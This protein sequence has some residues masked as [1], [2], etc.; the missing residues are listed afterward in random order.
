MSNRRDGQFLGITEA[1][2]TGD[3]LTT[4]SSREVKH[5][6]GMSYILLP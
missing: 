1:N 5:G 4:W 2:T 3:G 6:P